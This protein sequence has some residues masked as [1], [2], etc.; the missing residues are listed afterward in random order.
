MNDPTENKILMMQENLERDSRV[1]ILEKLIEDNIWK[2]LSFREAHIVY[3]WWEE[4]GQNAQVHAPVFLVKKQGHQL[5][6]REGIMDFKRK[7][8]G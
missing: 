7:G 5:N 6:G 3:L 2:S 4:W 1:N 8:L